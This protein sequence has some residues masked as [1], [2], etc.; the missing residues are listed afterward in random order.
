MPFIRAASKTLV[1]AGTRTGCPSRRMSTIPGGVV[2]VAMSGSN[3]NALG[4]AGARRG[5]EADAAGTL[6]LQ[7]VRIDFGSEMF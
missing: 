4:F 2:E 7:N 6:A 1:P 5:R 3:T